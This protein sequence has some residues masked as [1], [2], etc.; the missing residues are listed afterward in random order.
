MRGTTPLA[1]LA[2]CAVDDFDGH[3]RELALLLSAWQSGGARERERLGDPGTAMR[4]ALVCWSP[5]I[6]GP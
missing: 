3:V 6:L 1:H 5:R 2:H 4:I